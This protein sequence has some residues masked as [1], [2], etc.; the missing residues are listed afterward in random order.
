MAAEPIAYCNAVGMPFRRDTGAN[1]MPPM[2]LYYFRNLARSMRGVS[3]Q[4]RPKLDERSA[5]TFAAMLIGKNKNNQMNADILKGNWKITKGKL[6][7]K[8]AQLTD[9]DLAYVAGKE[10]EL[11][12]RIQK[13]TGRTREEIEDF[14][15]NQ[16]ELDKPV[17]PR[18]E[19]EENKRERLS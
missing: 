4:T 18:S 14:L 12:G 7:Q 10:E 5:P 16:S 19:R 1:E 6:K 17:L 13:R 3:S 2:A 9:D 15:E 8:Y 11:L